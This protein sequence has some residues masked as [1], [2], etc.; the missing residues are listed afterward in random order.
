V[1]AANNETGVLQPIAAIAARCAHHGLPLHCD[2]SQLPG[3]LPV[4]LPVD[5]LTLSSH[6]MGGPRGAG[7][8]LLRPAR[9][10]ALQ[11]RIR[12]GPQE[13][14]LRG[15]TENV[16]AIAGMG[17]AARLAGRTAPGPRDQ[18]EAACKRLGGRILGEGAPRLPNTTA[19]LFD[20][21]GDLIVMGLDL[22]GVCASTGSACASGAAEPSH[23]LAA[24]GLQGVPVRFSFGPDA[25]D[26]AEAIAALERVLARMEV[27]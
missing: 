7:A 12:G 18:L 27:A 20:R 9:M 16:P 2:A 14:G 21:P 19:V 25:T 24:M 13:R 6:K 4:D 22:D 17:E 1:M 8:L 3:R 5:L 11:P 15:G 23:V 26:P 10:A